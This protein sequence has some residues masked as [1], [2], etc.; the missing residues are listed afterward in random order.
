MPKLSVAAVQPRLTCDGLTAVAVRPVG[1][2]GGC[3]S[4]PWTTVV[5]TS[6]G[7]LETVLASREDTPRES[8]ETP[9]NAK[10][11]AP[12]PVTNGVTSYST[13][14]DT[15]TACLSS[16]GPL[17]GAGRSFQVVAVSAPVQLVLYT[18]GPSAVPLVTHR[19][20]FACSTVPERVVGWNRRRVCL[21]RA[22]PPS[23]Y[24]VVA[25]PKLVVGL[26]SSTR[27]SASGAN[28]CVVR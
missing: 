8:A 17:V 26:A 11:V 18:G 21:P 27:V 28:V 6:S 22:L 1:A 7:L 15:A 24:S 13:Q 10:L 25:V 14:A 23:T 4:E 5:T 3:V 16:V 12:F 9:I 20:S 19:R 2:V